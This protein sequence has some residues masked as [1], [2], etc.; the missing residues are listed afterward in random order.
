MAAESES[1]VNWWDS[2]NTDDSA[3]TESFAAVELR[4]FLS[5]IPGLSKR[6]IALRNTDEL[7]PRG[8]VVLIGT[9]ASNAL[10]SSLESSLRPSFP[11]GTPEAFRIYTVAQ[12][13]RT[14]Y[15]IE[16]ATRIGALY[17]VYE[18][19]GQLGF[20]FFVYNNSEKN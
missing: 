13:D 14:I 16:G 8:D 1:L 5:S 7:P 9:S 3:C 20:R 10:I 11:E 12:S 18:F 19:L 15:V 17:G 6:K 2:G 4:D